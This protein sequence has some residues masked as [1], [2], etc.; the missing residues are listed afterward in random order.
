MG[1]FMENN[2][3]VLDGFTLNPG[4]LSW[5]DLRLLGNCTIY[6]RTPP[7][8]IIER[9]KNC[10]IILT[11]KTV[12]TADIIAALP[13]LKY[14]GILATGVNVVDV[15]S[16][17]AHNIIVTNVP[18]YSTPS[19]VQAV[20]ALLLE[21]SNHIGYYNTQVHA[22][23]WSQSPDFC[24]YDRPTVE[25]AGLTF[26]I[27]GFGVIGQAVSHVA[28]TLDMQI[29]VHS[30][31]PQD[32]PGIKFV[33]RHA[34]LAKSDIISLHC[35][36]TAKTHHLINSETLTL[37]KKSAWLINTGRGDLI[38]EQALAIALDQGRIAGCAL[39]VLSTEPPEHD[40][41]LLRAK[42]CIITPHIAWASLAARTRLMN[43]AV[44]NVRQFLQGTPVNM[45]T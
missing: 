28:N 35:T 33:D 7:A 27:I 5:A 3:V 23:R 41:P 37:I 44:D 14:I 8:K 26:G 34:L 39:D 43:T 17:H 38:D 11:N 12:I 29:L 2:I 15:A 19:V 36:L 16:A 42:N 13:Q 22:G 31:T 45:V 6:D 18:D 40:N 25:L 4:D 1:D 9:A 30:R 20:F 21:L 24:F 32:I 10:T